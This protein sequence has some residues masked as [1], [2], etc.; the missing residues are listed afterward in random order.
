LGLVQVLHLL[1]DRAE[2]IPSLEAL[3]RSLL[4]GVRFGV[5][6]LGTGVLGVDLLGVRGFIGVL[7]VCAFIN[8]LKLNGACIL[9][10]ENGQKASLNL[11]Y[12]LLL[13]QVLLYVPYLK[14]V[15]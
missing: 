13:P 12:L 2:A 15:S 10:V 1:E 3:I 6:V 8:G 9:G 14:A 11:L 4:G 7:L 5:E